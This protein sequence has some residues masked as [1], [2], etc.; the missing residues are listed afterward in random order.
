MITIAGFQTVRGERDPRK[1]GKK[2]GGG[3]ELFDDNKWCNANHIM[4]KERF[5]SPG[6]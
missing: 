5:C 4:A 2:K 3:V 1:S 6:R